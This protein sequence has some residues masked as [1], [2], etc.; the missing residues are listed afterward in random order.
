M[1]YTNQAF[2]KVLCLLQESWSK[3][4]FVSCCEETGSTQKQK[5]IFVHYSL[6]Q[7]LFL[8]FSN[9]HHIPPILSVIIVSILNGLSPHTFGFGLT[10]VE[11]HL[12]SISFTFSSIFRIGTKNKFLKLIAVDEH[13][14]VQFSCSVVSNSLR[15]RGLQHANPPCPSP[16]PGVYSC[17][18]SW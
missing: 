5:V 14:S 17:P 18:L 6:Q 10:A 8:Q 1:G 9:I 7:I 12:C 13:P 16:T 4:L 15:P 11:S 2:L 3:E